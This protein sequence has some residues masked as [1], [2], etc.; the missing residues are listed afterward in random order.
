[1]QQNKEKQYFPWFDWLRAILAIM[2][3]LTHQ[4][5]SYWGLA[6]NFAV[7][8][9]FALSG[10]LIGGILLEIKASDLPRFYFNRALRI[11]APYYLALV[12]LVIASIIKEPITD[13]W[14]EF[15]FYKISFVHNIFGTTQ[16]S[17]FKN[18]MP[19]EGTG[20]HFWS[21]NAEEQFYL[22]APLLLVLIN[23]RFAK[24]IALWSLITFWAWYF[25]FYA[26]IVFGVLAA[27]ANNEYPE[28]YKKR[29]VKG[30]LMVLFLLCIYLLSIDHN[31]IKTAPVISILIVLLL[32]VDGPQTRL[33]AIVGGM[34]YQLYLNHWIGF[35]AAHAILNPLGLRNSIYSHLISVVLNIGIAIFLYWFMDRKINKFRDQWYSHQRGTHS[36]KIAYGMI[37]VGTTAGLILSN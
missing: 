21:V 34:S 19:L 13:K 28:F 2:V 25:N 26:S 8:V 1:M 14:L 33:G 15:I 7:Q 32:A 9:F 20:N 35:F 30:L 23:N 18:A 31:Y 29:N 6:G 27:V 24:S 4:G 16:L 37:V 22:L 36:I 10:W 3:M 17:V 5:I 11:W 12:L